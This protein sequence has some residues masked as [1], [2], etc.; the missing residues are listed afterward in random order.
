[1]A[2]RQTKLI[3]CLTQAPDA[4]ALTLLADLCKCPDIARHV[5]KHWLPFVVH[6]FDD[7]LLLIYLN[8]LSHPDCAA[9]LTDLDQPFVIARR[10][11]REQTGLSSAVLASYPFERHHLDVVISIG[12]LPDLIFAAIGDANA[13]MAVRRLVFVFPEEVLVAFAPNLAM[14]VERYPGLA[15]SEVLS[16]KL[17]PIL[18]NVAPAS[19]ST[20]S[21]IDL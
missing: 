1:M 20:G 7:R 12:L 9:A 19:F 2:F 14:L 4:G 10:L 3:G 17:M 13:L 6:G 8:L 5:V 15:Q 11:I 21:L 16:Q 18:R